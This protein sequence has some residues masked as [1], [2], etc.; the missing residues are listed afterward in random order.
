[1]PTYHDPSFSNFPRWMGDSQFP[2]DFKMSRHQLRLIQSILQ[3][4]IGCGLQFHLPGCPLQT[5]SDCSELCPQ[6]GGRIFTGPVQNHVSSKAGFGRHI[7]KDKPVPYFPHLDTTMPAL[8]PSTTTFFFYLL[9]Y[10]PFVWCTTDY[11]WFSQESLVNSRWSPRCCQQVGCQDK[12]CPTWLL[13]EG[14]W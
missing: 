10:S 4:F 11:L 14:N 2:G 1:M 9:V 13:K 8:L 7:T 12:G 6:E 3:F 5:Y